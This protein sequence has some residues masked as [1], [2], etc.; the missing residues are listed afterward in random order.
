[1]A[2]INNKKTENLYRTILAL[3][4]SVEAEGFFRDLLTESEIA[5]FGNRWQ[6]A[7]ML[8][9]GVSYPKIQ[10]V[11]GLSTRTIARISKWLNSGKGGY[12]LMIARLSHRNSS[13]IFKKS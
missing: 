7:Q 4:S 8:S 11:T 2:Q 10:A 13:K 3:K 12:K 5:E 1:M 6:A 9:G